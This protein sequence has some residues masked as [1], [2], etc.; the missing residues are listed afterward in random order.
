MFSEKKKKSIRGMAL[1]NILGDVQKKL[2]GGLFPQENEELE[3]D[4][5]KPAVIS[6]KDFYEEENG[7]EES[8]IDPKSKMA[9]P[10]KGK[11]VAAKIEI[12]AVSPMK[13][14]N[15]IG[16]NY[17]E[18]KRKYYDSLAPMEDLSSINDSEP[19]EEEEGNFFIAV[20]EEG[21]DHPIREDAYHL[22]KQKIE[23]G[24]HPN[25]RHNGKI[26]KINYVRD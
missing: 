7:D 23:Q 4:E 18:S 13:G 17:D 26:L 22:F 5:A 24:K 6:D 15:S 14:K 11:P 2:L 3:E 25:I 20:D 16:N 21:N 19:E 1:D 9:M 8:S 10:I 12:E